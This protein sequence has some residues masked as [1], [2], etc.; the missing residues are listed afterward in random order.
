MPGWVFGLMVFGGLWLCLWMTA[1]V[2]LLRVVPFTIGAFAA[3]LSPSPDLLIAGDGRH[4]AIV[5]PEGVPMMLRDRSGEFTRD[6]MTEASGFD[7]E[8]GLLEEA[9]FSTCSRDA[10]LASV[11]RDGR[12]YRLLATRSATRIDWKS[13]VQAC[14]DADIV[15]SDR[16][17]PRGCTPRWLKLDRNALARTGGLTIHLG[18]RPK[19]E[20]VAERLG[21]HPWAK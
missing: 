1:R 6:L 16:R 2:R 9:A 4:L 13:L 19:V 20:T 14:E 5:D 8:P 18:D 3:A 21:Q 12:E 15:V 17:L 11:Q 7:E 10:C